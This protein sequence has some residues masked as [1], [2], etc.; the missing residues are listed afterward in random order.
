[1]DR[2]LAFLAGAIAGGTAVGLYPGRFHFRG[3][4]RAPAGEPPRGG[5]EADRAPATHHETA[6]LLVRIQALVGEIRSLARHAEAGKAK[7]AVRLPAEFAGQ[8][9]LLH[10]MIWCCGAAAAGFG[11]RK[12]GT[13]GT[14]LAAGGGLLLFA[15]AARIALKSLPGAEGRSHVEGAGASGRAGERAGKAAG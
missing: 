3:R 9:W 12:G 14:I 2:F 10:G 13:S 8:A 4:D 6:R 5:A 1:M 7:A 11:F 15:E